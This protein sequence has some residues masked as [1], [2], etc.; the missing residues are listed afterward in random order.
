MAFL[1]QALG[2]LQGI[3]FQTLPPSHL[4][5]G[6]MQLPIMT[7]TERNGELVADFETQSSGLSKAQMMRII[8]SP[9]DQFLAG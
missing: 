9:A 2:N 3:D 4:I 1:P 7:A 5:A 8:P 6:L